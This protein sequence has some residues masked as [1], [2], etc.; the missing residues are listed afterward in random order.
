MQLW[1]D[2]VHAAITAM[3]YQRL[4]QWMHVVYIAEVCAVLLKKSIVSTFIEMLVS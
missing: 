4:H 2:N 1:Y 3:P